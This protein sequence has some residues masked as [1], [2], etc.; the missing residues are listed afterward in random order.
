ML[1]KKE[2]ETP[3]VNSYCSPEKSSEMTIK[4]NCTTWVI[5]QNN[6]YLDDIVINVVVSHYLSQSLMPNIVR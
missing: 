3:L 1:N 5:V 2:Q 6:I 4:D